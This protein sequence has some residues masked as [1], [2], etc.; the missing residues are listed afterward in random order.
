MVRLERERTGAASLFS[1]GRDEFELH[2]QVVDRAGHLKAHGHLSRYHFG[3][4]SG[5][6]MQSRIE[7]CVK[8][9]PDFLRDV[10]LS[11]NALG[12]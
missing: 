9:D 6:T 11:V 8:V 3:H 4:P 1:I 10:T 5:K 2:L 7:Y 12:T